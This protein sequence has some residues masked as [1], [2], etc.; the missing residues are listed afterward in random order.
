MGGATGNVTTF[1]ALFGWHEWAP[2]RAPAKSEAIEDVGLG[3]GL[4][5]SEGARLQTK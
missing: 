4:S 3:G 5:A 1:G 2:S